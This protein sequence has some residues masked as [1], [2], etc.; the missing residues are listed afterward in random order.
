MANKFP[1]VKIMTPRGRAVFPKLDKPDTKWKAEG[2]YTVKLV[3]SADGFDQYKD[4]IAS[5]LNEYESDTR[6]RLASGDGKAKAKAKSISRR[7]EYF[8]AE[9]DDE[10][11]E[12]GNIVANFK[13]TA[14]GVSKKDGKPWS[15]KPSVFDAKGKKLDPCPPVWGGS[16][17]KV[18]A[19]AVPYYN[20]KDNEVGITLRLNAVQIIDLKTGSNRDAADFGFGEEEGFTKADDSGGFSDETASEGDDF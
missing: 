20:P 4:A 14:S 3:L 19:D 10:G 11:E 18:A 8:T 16:I 17:L 12:T 2:Q 13:M 9:V 15:R 6:E 1:A 7:E 5:M